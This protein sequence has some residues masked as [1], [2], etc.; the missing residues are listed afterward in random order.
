[1]G[2]NFG[3]ET[4]FLLEARKISRS[5]ACGCIFSRLPIVQVVPFWV[6]FGTGVASG[7]VRLR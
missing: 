4:H 3:A 2:L 6:L 5:R 1:V 7:A